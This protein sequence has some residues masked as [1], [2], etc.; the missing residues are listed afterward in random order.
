[1]RRLN[2]SAMNGAVA[3][4]SLQGAM[5]VTLTAIRQKPVQ[6]MPSRVQPANAGGVAECLARPV[7]CVLAVGSYWEIVVMALAILGA[8][9]S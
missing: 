5:S 2:T 4:N 3:V 1:M 9:C 7:G 8:S 6:V